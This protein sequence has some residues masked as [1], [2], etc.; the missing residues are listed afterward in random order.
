MICFLRIIFLFPRRL[1]SP[2]VVT[3]SAG[4][5]CAGSG[6][7][8]SSGVSS[9]GSSGESALSSGS[10]SS[11]S[12]SSIIRLSS[13]SLSFLVFLPAVPR[14]AGCGISESSSPSSDMGWALESS[15]LGVAGCDVFAFFTFVAALENACIMLEVLEPPR[16][17]AGVDFLSGTDG[18]GFFDSAGGF[19]A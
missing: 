11:S 12:S 2:D 9:I 4:S 19:S 18:A 6:A 3:T 16:F 8:G 15:P 7:A 17:R 1:P 10:S 14:G 5:S 13:S